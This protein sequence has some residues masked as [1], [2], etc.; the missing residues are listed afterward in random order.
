MFNASFSSISA[1][2]WHVFSFDWY[3]IGW[4]FYKFSAF[5]NNIA[6][7]HNTV[8]TKWSS[9][10][11]LGVI[12]FNLTFNNISAISSPSVLLL[13]YQEKSTD[14]LQVTGKLYHMMLYRV[15]HA[16]IAQ[17]VENPTAIW[18]IITM[19]PSSIWSFRYMNHVLCV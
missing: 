18:S 1:I 2:L 8:L 14:L 11:R 9:I 7:I 17:V 12:V 19:A 5:Y 15:H 4:Y 6:L 13:E 10:W 3:I 16:L